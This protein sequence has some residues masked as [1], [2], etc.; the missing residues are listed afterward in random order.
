MLLTAFVAAAVSLG[1]GYALGPA[2]GLVK[3]LPGASEPLHKRIVSEALAPREP[4]AAPLPA[5]P[6]NP[7]ADVERAWLLSEG[8]VRDRTSGRRLVTLTFDDGPGPVSTPALLRELDR[9]DARATFF[10]IGEYLTG[11][12]PRAL[13]VRAAARS[14]AERGHGIGSH[15]LDH[16]LLTVLPKAEVARQIE[17]AHERITI[18]TGVSPSFFRPPYGALDAYG[19]SLVTAHRYSLVLWSIEAQ[20]MVRD[21]EDGVFEDIRRQLEY[22]EGGV[23]LLH[24]I[25]MQTV[26]VTARLLDYLRKR[27][28]DPRN[29]KHVGFEIVDLPTYLAETKDRPQP[30]ATRTELA[31]ARLASWRR[32][33]PPASAPGT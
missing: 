23:V 25:K 27:R 15:S 14:I 12:T 29:P 21:D 4:A 2:L 20:D 3:A 28:F 9:F 18:A 32:A 22:A 7:E 8:P 31:Q 10:L 16:Y 6:L 19:S 5:D 11:E 30:F 24:D 1:A 13:Q 26:R 17:E 33:H